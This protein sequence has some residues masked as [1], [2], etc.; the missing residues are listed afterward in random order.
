MRGGAARLEKKS[1]Q[2]KGTKGNSQW[3]LKVTRDSWF[4][5]IHT[6]I[7]ILRRR[8]RNSESS[9]PG[10]WAFVRR[11]KR[12]SLPQ[13]QILRSLEEGRGMAQKKKNKQ[14]ETDSS[15]CQNKAGKLPGGL[16]AIK[17]GE[18]NFEQGSRRNG[19]SH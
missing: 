1:F 18:K 8:K 12:R 6:H 10:A 4:G 16:S 9:K 11:E 3:E 17:P 14:N 13:K 15:L 2:R 7:G 19:R 5:N